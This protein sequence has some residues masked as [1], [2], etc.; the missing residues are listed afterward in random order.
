MK[1]KRTA[2]T[3]SIGAAAGLAALTATLMTAS[4]ASAGGLG[5]HYNKSMKY[6]KTLD[7]GTTVG[8]MK[9]AQCENATL[10]H[11]VLVI[12]AAIS[13]QSAVI[14]QINWPGPGH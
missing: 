4:P 3:L 9:R 10:A 2:R 7:N 6:C 5:Y 12:N 14:H 1:M 13:R 8:A 11:Q